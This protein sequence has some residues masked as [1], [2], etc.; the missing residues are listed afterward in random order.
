MRAPQIISHELLKRYGPDF[1][2]K[3]SMYRTAKLS[4]RCVGICE[5]DPNTLDVL[6]KTSS[7]AHINCTV[8]D[9]TDFVL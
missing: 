1:R 2:K 6:V 5:V 3:L 8:N 9:L 7:G 4:G